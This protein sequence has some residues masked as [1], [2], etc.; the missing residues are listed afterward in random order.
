M[1]GAVVG[2]GSTP[3]VVATALLFGVIAIGVGM[4]VIE[5]IWLRRRNSVTGTAPPRR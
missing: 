3:L 1:I 5:T 4:W 2:R